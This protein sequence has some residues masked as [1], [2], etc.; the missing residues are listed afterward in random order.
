MPVLTPRRVAL[1]AL[2]AGGVAAALVVVLLPLWGWRETV[3][4]DLPQGM[5]EK[6]AH[7]PSGSA[8]SPLRIERVGPELPSISDEHPGD[9]GL[10][11]PC[12]GCLGEAGALD[13]AQTFIYHMRY[14]DTSA[15][16]PNSIRPSPLDLRPQGSRHLTGR[17]LRGSL[18]SLGG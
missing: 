7:L 3:V 11:P 16:G 4:A 6:P 13:V 5:V 1:G 10:G 18:G 14:Q 9:D 12:E 15:P 8:A 17:R 2:A